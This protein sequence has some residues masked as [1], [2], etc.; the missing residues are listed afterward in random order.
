MLSRNKWVS[1]S[2]LWI[3][4]NL[5]NPSYWAYFCLKLLIMTNLSW[6]KLDQLISGFKS[7]QGKNSFNSCHEQMPK[8]AFL[9]LYLSGSGVVLFLSTSIV[10]HH[11][12][13][14]S[15]SQFHGFLAGMRMVVGLVQVGETWWSW[16]WRQLH[17]QDYIWNTFEIWFGA[18]LAGP[19]TPPL[20]SVVMSPLSC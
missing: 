1:I 7:I 2:S 10:C 8:S 16:W 20:Q 18:S 6:N 4:Q 11:E 13:K 17:T 12:L 15:Q 3:K 14:N 5:L 9:S 19:C